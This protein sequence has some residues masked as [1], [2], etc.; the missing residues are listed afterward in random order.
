MSDMA[1]DIRVRGR[2]MMAGQPLFGAIDIG[3]S[4][5][6]WTCVLGPSG[7]GKTTL[8]RL[9]A[10]LECAGEFEGEIVTS[11]AR[12]IAGRVSFMAQ[13]DLLLPW[14][15]V[16]DNSVLGA[17]LRGEVPDMARAEAMI[18][19]V[20]LWAHRDKTPDA[21]SG[22]MRQRVALAR[23]L[24]E[25]RPI[26]FLDEPFSALDA[27]TRAEMQELASEV[28]EGKTVL[29]VTHDPGEAL[30]LGHQILVLTKEGA[31][32]WTLPDEVPL[33]DLYAPKAAR[34]QAELLGHLRG[35]R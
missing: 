11:D 29:L 10:G 7:V 18:E 8:L 32:E 27:S 35:I 22:G 34:C 33:R 16:R 14:L 31:R 26:A 30:R 19:R 5:G 23:T 13:T 25:D 12:P 1:P 17:R 20:G 6:R 3:L 4:A 21:L 2:H 9:I 15:T 28:L 24:M